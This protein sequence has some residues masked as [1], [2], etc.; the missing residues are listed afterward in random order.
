MKGAIG[1][2]GSIRYERYDPLKA[3]DYASALKGRKN[4][5]DECQVCE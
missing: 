4:D 2:F 3:K 1:D 5:S